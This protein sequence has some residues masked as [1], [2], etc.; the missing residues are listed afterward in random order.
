MGGPEVGFDTSVSDRQD[1]SSLFLYLL[2][3]LSHTNRARE[4][5]NVSHPRK[6]NT[7]TAASKSFNIR[8]GTRNENTQA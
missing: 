8:S 2:L 3:T 6:S 4:R 5:I 1:V 7:R